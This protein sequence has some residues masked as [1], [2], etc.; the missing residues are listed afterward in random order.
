MALIDEVKDYIDSN[1]GEFISMLGEALNSPDDTFYSI[2]DLDEQLDG[3]KPSEI[4]RKVLNGDFSFNDAKYFSYDGY[5][6]LKSYSQ[7]QA[8]TEVKDY[9]SDIAEYIIGNSGSVS[10]S[11]ELRDILDKGEE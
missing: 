8:E 5:A 9:D 2:N 3:L 4:I 11:N 10:I 7:S 6:N 1:P